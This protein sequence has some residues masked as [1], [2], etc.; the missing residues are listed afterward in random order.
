MNYFAVI[1]TE[2]NWHDQVMSIGVVIANETDMTPIDSRYYLISPECTKP[3]MYSHAL[4]ICKISKI[5]LRK[6]ILLDLIDFLER[7]HIT[8]IFAYNAGFDYSHLKELSSYDWYDILKIAA[9]KQTNHKIVNQ[10]C[11]KT[12]R[13]KSHYGVEAILQLLMEDPSYNETHNGLLDAIDE[14]KIMYY[15]GHSLDVYEKA[16]IN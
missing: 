12:G 11:C 10:F 14:L 4:N 1:D 5:G 6:D 16:K 15:L 13:L 2:T 8:S 9:Y 3:G 7:Y